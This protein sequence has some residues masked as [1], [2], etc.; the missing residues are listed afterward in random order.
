MNEK[1]SPR[2]YGPYTVLKRIGPVAYKLDLPP[3]ARIHTVFHI[4]QLKKSLHQSVPIQPLPEALSDDLELFVQPDT[5][6]SVRTL[7]DGSKEVLIKWQN[8]LE[9]EAT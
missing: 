3:T 9:F 7:L 6:L 2:F 4:S 8:L 1:L 5:V